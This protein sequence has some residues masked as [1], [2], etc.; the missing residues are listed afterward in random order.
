M[1]AAALVAA[2]AAAA[3]LLLHRHER[4]EEPAATPPPPPPAAAPP[5]RSL[6][7]PGP[8]RSANR[9]CVKR[10][11]GREEP[12]APP[13]ADGWP[14][15]YPA[16]LLRRHTGLAPVRDGF[17]AS[18]RRAAGGPRLSWTVLELPAGCALLPRASLAHE[19]VYVARGQAVS[20][21]VR[22]CAWAAAA[23]AAA[24]GAARPTAAAQAEVRA[25]AEAAGAPA[26]VATRAAG[27]AADAPPG[28]VQQL[29]GGPTGCVLVLLW[30]ERSGGVW[31]RGL[32][33][34]WREAG[35]TWFH[36]AEFC[37]CC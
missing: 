21:A 4:A 15:A 35:R 36:S 37:D 7:V 14:G 8:R 18:W 11:D 24:A 28:T 22:G 10:Y 3:A 26:V 27:D 30:A 6:F 12:P 29:V 31:L 16:A 33:E 34:G 5:P 2:G 17:D 20:L 19:Y 32:E 23:A 1:T 9:R 25:A 13:R